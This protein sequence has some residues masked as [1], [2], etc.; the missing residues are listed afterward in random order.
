MSQT[1]R[2][3]LEIDSRNAEQKAADTRKALKE[4]EDAG[5]RVP[6]NLKMVSGTIQDVGSKSQ[7]AAPKT[8]AMERQIRS[9][10]SAAAGLAGP[11]AAAFSVVEISKAAGEYTNITNRLRLVTDGSL[12]LALAQD[13][14][15]KAAQNSRQSLESTAQVYQRI[16][17]NA[18][19]L[20]L[21]FDQ[22]AEITE[23]VAKSVALSGASA[24]AAEAALVQFGQALASGTLRGDELNSILEQ[25]PALAQAIARGLGVSVGALRSMG[26]EGQLTSAKIVEAL[27]NQKNKVDELSNSLQVTSSQAFTAFT[28]SLTVAIGKLDEATTASSSFAKGLLSIS[29]GIDR[30]NNGDFLDFFREN[31]Q[32]ISGLNSELSETTSRIRDL[33]DVRAQLI[34]GK[35][36]DT[37]LYDFKFYDVDDLDKEI[38]DLQKRA[39][40]INGMRAKLQKGAA[41][42]GAQKP[43]GDDPSTV[44]NPA[45]E[46]LLANLK[47]QAALQGQN[48]ELAKV[49]YAIESGELGKLLPAQQQLLI[50]Y[51]KEKDQKA[52]AEA[53][54][55]KNAEQTEQA[56]NATQRA[57]DT[58]S[59]G[60]QR[61]IDLINLTTSKKNEA[62]EATKLA[63]ET[64]SGKLKNLT[65]QQ[66]A[67]LATK[68]DE[69]DA[70]KQ[71]KA[72]N[73][74]NAKFTAYMTAQQSQTAALKNGYDLDLAGLGS[75]D[76]TRERLREQL[77]L[78]Q[79]YETD[80]K[81]LTAQRTSGDITQDEYTKQTEVLREELAKRLVDQQDY[82]NQLDQAQSNWA[83]GASSAFQT[84]AD[85]A[86][87]VAGQ[88]NT[89]FTNA[90]SNMEDGIVNFVKT[91]KLSF[92]D[93]ADG[94]ISDLI[95][96]QVRQ[97]AVGLF[98]SF[99]G[100][101]FGFGFSSGGYTG[102]GGKFEPKGVVH[103]GEFVVQKSVVQQPGM[104]EY[105]ER[106]NSSGKGY[107]D[108]GYVNPAGAVAATNAV[109]RSSSNNSMPPIQQSIV[110]QGTADD[111]TLA[112]IQ[113]AA[114]QG[115]QDGYNLVLRDLKRNGP[116][117]QLIA[118]NR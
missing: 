66:K 11:L 107:A 34:K 19:Q 39:D 2:L 17:Q 45:Y 14:V 48:T 98:G 49:R 15:F 31:K 95:R 53:A 46:K 36:G 44:V 74:E 104:R 54:S 26:A 89:L 94:I 83:L 58:A 113:Q 51:A 63:F 41:D 50:Q 73:E 81:A 93:L 4:L 101:G 105:L 86:R 61:E 8:M 37:K 71:I 23:T 55:K 69:L 65:D 35:A 103:G 70:L 25:T 7:I 112:R 22:V 99:T 68:A 40:A 109:A 62:S 106:M 5:L 118:R 91:G 76:K 21:S 27:Q 75:S 100:A 84:Y 77:Q 114:Q 32:T 16:A 9:L 117:R 115:A 13:S 116:A 85:K 3:V 80:L 10:A 90:F 28:N 72:A 29:Q 108:G 82:Y 43:K 47:Q 110:V 92:S 88:T 1:S 78:R 56:R 96:I 12:Q 111:A 60:Y 52:A 59:E 33:N 57:F 24:Q 38:A 97:A 79:Q 102:D 67:Y 18:S 42:I 64:E 30:V 20:G 87:D 6:P